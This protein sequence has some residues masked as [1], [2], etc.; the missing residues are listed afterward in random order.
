MATSFLDLPYELRERI[1]FDCLV[2]AE[3][4]SLQ[5]DTA[6]PAIARVSRVVREE[7]LN[8]YYSNSTFVI[9]THWAAAETPQLLRDSLRNLGHHHVERIRRLRLE[10]KGYCRFQGRPRNYCQQAHGPLCCP[11]HIGFACFSNEQH[12]DSWHACWLINRYRGLKVSCVAPVF[13]IAC[14]ITFV[15]HEPWAQ[16]SIQCASFEASETF[17]A[18]TAA[19]LQRKMREVLL[20]SL[21]G[22]LPAEHRWKQLNAAYLVQMASL[23]KV[24]ASRVAEDQIVE[25]RLG[26]QRPRVPLGGLWPEEMRSF[27]TRWVGTTI[28]REDLLPA[29]SPTWE[30]VA[31][32]G[33]ETLDSYSG[34][35]GADP[36]VA[37]RIARGQ[38]DRARRDRGDP[39]GGPGSKADHLYQNLP[40]EYR[41][42]RP[43]VQAPRY[44]A[45]GTTPGLCIP[46]G[47]LRVRVWQSMRVFRLQE[48]GYR[49]APTRKYSSRERPYIDLGVL[50]ARPYGRGGRK[51]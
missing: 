27:L 3:H 37:G 10:L 16:I 2:Q 42:R 49:F 4:I 19:V 6:V 34:A 23:W 22:S 40:Y 24:W 43:E 20:P 46:I 36:P 8:V 26:S 29:R 31:L 50:S 21:Q 12:R 47:F 45:M 7:S 14:C 15:P 1:Y 25:L 11:R 28:Q 51:W 32:Q 35:Q 9:S 18:D 33:I 17:D 13:R 41:D 48:Q 39:L 5:E 44:P 30:Q 38:D